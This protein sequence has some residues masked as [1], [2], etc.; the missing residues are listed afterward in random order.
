MVESRPRVVIID[1]HA[2]F[3]GGL[4]QLLEERGIAVVG[5]AGLALD[6][7]RQ[8]AEL[9]PDVALMDLSMPGLSGIAAT[10]RLSASAPL[11]RVLVLTVSADAQ[12]VTDA[13]LAGACGYLLKDAS[14]EQIAE[15]IRAAARGESSISPRVASQLVRRLRE[16]P[17][18]ESHPVGAELTPREL[19]V[20]EL[21]S[22]GVDNPGIARALHLSQHTVKNHVSSILVKLQVENRIQAAVRA[23]RGRLV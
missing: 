8:V 10:Q 3:R 4:V 15:G 17:E 22:K 16:P 14:I 7:I 13:L 2:L 20:L 23:V 21:L 12:S 11:V 6:G 5:E 1:D 18:A 19:E 9:A